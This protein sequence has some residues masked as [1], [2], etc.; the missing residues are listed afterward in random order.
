M[1]K[2]LEI[3]RSIITKH[4]KHIWRNFIRAVEKYELVDEN[5]KIMVCLSGIWD[6]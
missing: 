6:G 1:N 5:D 2:S 3:E 4:R